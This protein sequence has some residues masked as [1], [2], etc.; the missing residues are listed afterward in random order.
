LLKEFFKMQIQQRTWTVAD[1]WS[2]AQNGGRGDHAGASV[3]QPM[4]LV[5][6]FG[7]PN[8]LKQPGWYDQLRQFYPQARL[9]GCSTAGEI[10]GTQVRDDGLV[11]TAIGFE[12]TQVKAAAIALLPGE[13]SFAAGARLGA[14]IEAAQLVHVFVLSDGLQVNGSDLVRGLTSQLPPGVTL[15][16]GLAGDGDR[17][18]ET[19]VCL[20][21]APQS[22]MIAAVGLYGSDLRV[23]YGSLGG[24]T[25]FGPDRRITKSVGN[26]LYE[27]DG[28]PALEL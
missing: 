11:A 24:W 21:Q 4:Q 20:D 10:A 2:V 28:K 15:T 6:V 17:F 13:S 3:D 18:A 23:G 5:L 1:G 22:G 25:P 27:L 19:L 9:L 16:G 12:Q 8:S 26:V 14:T 7:S